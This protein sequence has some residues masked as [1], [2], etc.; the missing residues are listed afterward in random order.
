VAY[1]VRIAT[2]HTDPT[3]IIRAALGALAN[4]AGPGIDLVAH[5]GDVLA[6]I[7]QR[8]FPTTSG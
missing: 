1:G 8:P 7:E 2:D 4:R 3:P 6:R 5:D